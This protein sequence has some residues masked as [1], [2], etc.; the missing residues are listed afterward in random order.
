MCLIVGMVASGQRA[1]IRFNAAQLHVGRGLD[2]SGQFK[3][4]GVVAATGSFAID[5]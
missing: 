5:A 4:Q 1:F 2:V 3:G